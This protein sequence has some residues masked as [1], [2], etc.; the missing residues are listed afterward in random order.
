MEANE[1]HES[2]AQQVDHMRPPGLRP[3]IDIG[4]EVVDEVTLRI[5]LHPGDAEQRR[6]VDVRYDR[7]PD[8]YTVT[9]HPPGQRGEPISDVYCDQLGELIFGREDALPWRQP[10]GGIQILDANGNVVEEHR[11]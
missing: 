4:M 3:G 6:S 7:G 9:V 10:Y 8:T 1:I 11:F 2:I 5:M